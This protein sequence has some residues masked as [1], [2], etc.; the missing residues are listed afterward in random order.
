MFLLKPHDS[1][2]DFL[3]QNYYTLVTTKAPPILNS[4]VP[5]IH[6][7]RD[8]PVVRG[9]PLELVISLILCA[10]FGSYAGPSSRTFVPSM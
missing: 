6:P 1:V 9:Y 10:Q 7:F 4:R 8:G 5:P 2:E 3:Y